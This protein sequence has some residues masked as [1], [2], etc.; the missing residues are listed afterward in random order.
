VKVT[1]VSGETT[2]LRRAAP[3]GKSSR[4]SRCQPTPPPSARWSR[5]S[6]P[7]N[8]KRAGR[9]SKSLEGFGLKPPK[10]TVAFK[11]AGE[12]AERKLLLGNKTPTGSDLY[13]QVEG[14]PR[15]ILISAYLNDT[16]N[17][18]TFD[19]RDKTALKFDRGAVDVVTIEATGAPTTNFTRK[20]TSGRSRRRSTPAPTSPPSTRSSAR[21][22]RRR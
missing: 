17:R 6:R 8:S 20:A 1:S 12:T 15:V 16:F 10:T 7:S 2:T 22:S 18:T 14:Q 11:V 4:P 3:T 5:R 13:A 21:F 9:K 19:L